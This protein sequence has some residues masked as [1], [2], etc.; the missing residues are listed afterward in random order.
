MNISNKVDIIFLILSSE[1]KYYDMFV[2]NFWLPFIKVCEERELSI[3]FFFMYGKNKNI[4]NLIPSKYLL[5]TNIEEEIIPGCLNKTIEGYKYVL[6]NY[7]FNYIFRCNLSAFII[8][9]HFLNFYDTIKNNDYYIGCPVKNHACQK[10]I[11]NFMSGAGFFTSKEYSKFL[12]KSIL[13][14]KN[15]KSLRHFPD[16][17]AIGI[18]LNKKRKYIKKRL[19]ISSKLLWQSGNTTIFVKNLLTEKNIQNI[20]NIC[21][22]KIYFKSE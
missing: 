2:S 15:L 13:K 20:F 12:L 18:I 5:E 6:K 21:K 16:D 14:K 10:H 4:N 19:D 7:D 11:D 1:D 9:D 22:K 3:R 8:I 17:V